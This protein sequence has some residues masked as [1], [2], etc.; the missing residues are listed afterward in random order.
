[1]KDWVK[2][3][4][5]QKSVEALQDLGIDYKEDEV[6]AKESRE[7]KVEQ[8]EFERLWVEFPVVYRVGWHTVTGSTVNA[9]SQGLMVES[10]L[11][12]KSASKVFNTLNKKTGYRVEVEY[13]YQGKTYRRNAEIKH[14]HLDF[15]GSQPYRFTVGFWIPRRERNRKT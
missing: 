3:Y 15:A 7:L 4:L 5:V 9:S 8:R 6:I 13:T 2:P 14:F 12:S 10:Y 11:S 1:M